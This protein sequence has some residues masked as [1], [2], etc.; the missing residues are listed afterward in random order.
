MRRER[1]TDLE[2]VATAAAWSSGRSTKVKGA[3]AE[4][5]RKKAGM[6]RG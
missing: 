6:G 3:E 1:P 2:S 4:G 5:W